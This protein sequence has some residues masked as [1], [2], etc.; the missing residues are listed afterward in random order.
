M[1]D[2]GILLTLEFISQFSRLFETIKRW[3]KWMKPPCLPFFHVNQFDCCWVIYS[4]RKGKNGMK[5]AD[6]FLCPTLLT[7]SL[8]NWGWRE[9]CS[10]VSLTRSWALILPTWLVCVCVCVCVCTSSSTLTN[11]WSVLNCTRTQVTLEY[12]SRFP[13][14]PYSH[15]LFH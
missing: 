8:G 7:D 2:D 6:L 14:S 12:W 10:C 5:W 9:K 4:Q 3:L 1:D 11:Q 15:S 13:L